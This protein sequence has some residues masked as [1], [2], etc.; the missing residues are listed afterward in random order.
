MKKH[1]HAYVCSARGLP[2]IKTH[3]FYFILFSLLRIIVLAIL[4]ELTHFQLILGTDVERL[5]CSDRVSTYIR[6]PSIKRTPRHVSPKH[7]ISIT[8]AVTSKIDSPVTVPNIIC[9]NVVFSA[10]VSFLPPFPHSICR[11]VIY[12]LH[13]KFDPE[14]RRSS[15]GDVSCI[16]PLAQPTESEIA[17][18][19][20]QTECIDY[21]H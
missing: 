18:W 7:A 20:L 6:H 19:C 2:C 15:L 10:H 11:T 5:H 3:S 1:Y 8:H 14:L 9:N 12:N 16:C 17:V 21:E 4:V 13:H